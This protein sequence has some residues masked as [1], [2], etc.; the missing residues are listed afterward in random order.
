MFNPT[1]PG[2]D[3]R[4]AVDVGIVIVARAIVVHA[5]IRRPGGIPETPSRRGN[6]P[7]AE[8]TNVPRFPFAGS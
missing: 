7:P 4:V 1:A 8:P 5:D 2:D 6:S 3:V